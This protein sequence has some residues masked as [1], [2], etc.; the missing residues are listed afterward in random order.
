[1][2]VLLAPEKYQVKKMNT[3]LAPM[4]DELQL[5]WNMIIMYDVFTAFI[6]RIVSSRD[7]EFTLYGILCWCT[8]DF[9]EYIVVFGKKRDVRN[10]I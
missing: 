10:D 6:H 8:Y 9:P 4:I 2:L 3:Y 7:H 1:M 5:L